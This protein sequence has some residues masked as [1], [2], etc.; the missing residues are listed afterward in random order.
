[1]RTTVILDRDVRRLL[2][3]AEQRSGRSFD[4]VLNDAVRA[5]LGRGFAGRM[6]AFKQQVFSLGA[7]EVDLTK[8]T[9]MAADLEDEA[10][11]AKASSAS[12]V[13]LSRC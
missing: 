5:G 1:M 7:A 8:A 6:P 10:V 3:D 12:Q 11:I 2:K 13:R 4:E 9:A